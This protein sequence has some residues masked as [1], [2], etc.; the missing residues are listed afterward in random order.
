MF[1]KRR[2]KEIL[3]SLWKSTKSIKFFENKALEFTSEVPCPPIVLAYHHFSDSPA[4][5]EYCV[6]TKAIESQIEYLIKNG[7]TFL[8]QNEYN[9]FNKKTVIIS[10]DDGWMD[11]YSLMFPIIQKYRIKVTI[12]LTVQKTLVDK[13][14]ESYFSLKEIST[15]LNSGLVSFE[16]HSMSHPHLTQCTD[17]ELE[18]ELSESQR[19]MKEK[20]NI[21]SRVLVSPFEDS[22]VRVI[23]AIKKYYDMG[24]N[25][26]ENADPL[27]SIRRVYMHENTSKKDIAISSYYHFKKHFTN[28]HNG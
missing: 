5:D 21:D 4:S 12:N 15:M 25:F 1:F 3:W 2:V 18:Y 13:P 19:L 14:T 20:L 23:E 26:V 10:I 28:E 24:Y 17:K 9:K 7:Y 6:S 11:N 27:Y 16:S 22:N 8:W